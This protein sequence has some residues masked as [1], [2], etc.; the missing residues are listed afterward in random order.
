[1]KKRAAWTMGVGEEGERRALNQRHI[2]SSSP[3]PHLVPIGKQN[4]RLFSLE[5]SI[6]TPE[7]LLE[8]GRHRETFPFRD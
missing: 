6:S 7:F 1:M 5:G 3:F 8:G 4:A 2:A